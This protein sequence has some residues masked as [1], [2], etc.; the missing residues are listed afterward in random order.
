VTVE[1]VTSTEKDLK[2]VPNIFVQTF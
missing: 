1:F 2:F